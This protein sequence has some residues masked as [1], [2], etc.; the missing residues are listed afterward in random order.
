MTSSFTKGWRGQ[1]HLLTV[2]CCASSHK[3][4][5]SPMLKVEHDELSM[6]TDRMT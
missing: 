5:N 6:V 2:T 1:N 3:D 4:S